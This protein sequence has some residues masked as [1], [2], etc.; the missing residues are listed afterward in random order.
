MII[1]RNYSSPAR[2]SLGWKKKHI[3]FLINWCLWTE[4]LSILC[5]QYSV[6]ALPCIELYTII[7]TILVR[8]RRHARFCLIR[9]QHHFGVNSLLPNQQKCLAKYIF[10]P[11]SMEIFTDDFISSPQF[12]ETLYIDFSDVLHILSKYVNLIFHVF[13]SIF[14]EY[15]MYDG[16]FFLKY[17][18]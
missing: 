3:W 4:N 16:L 17:V 6:R 14:I 13:S 12:K 10:Q 11:S 1:D 5:Y 8:C 15:S 9:C 18:D 7:D 2:I